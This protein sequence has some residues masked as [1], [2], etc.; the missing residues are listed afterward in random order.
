MKEIENINPALQEG[1]NPNLAPGMADK[2]ENEIVLA[3][4][5]S[6]KN[7]L[8]MIRKKGEP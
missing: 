5:V 1:S 2:K 6:F 4:G 3:G 7:I 8:K